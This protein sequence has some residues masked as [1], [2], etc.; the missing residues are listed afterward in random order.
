MSKSKSEWLE[1]FSHAKDGHILWDGNAE[2]PYDPIHA[3][4]RSHQFVSHAESLGFF[5]SGDRVLD[6]GCG[7]GRFGIALSERHVLYEGIDPMLPCIDFCKFAFEGCSNLNFSHIDVCNDVSNPSG[8]VQPENFAIPFEANYFENVI[9]YS[10]F[11]H[12][13]TL[14]VAQHYISEISRVL[15]PNGKLFITCYRSPPDPKPDININR[16]VYSESD[17]INMMND[18][19]FLHTYGGHSAMFYDQWAIFCQKIK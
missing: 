8:K 19:K 11:T 12:L 7:N 3:Y 9:C 4:N 5:K 17:I 13:E 14:G 10:I 16:T 15:K 1:L 2:N 6:L 18:F